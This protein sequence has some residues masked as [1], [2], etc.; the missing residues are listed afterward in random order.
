VNKWFKLEYYQLT[1]IKAEI[2]DL[3]VLDL[4]PGQESKC[5]EDEILGSQEYLQ[6]IKNHTRKT[7]H[8]GIIGMRF[9]I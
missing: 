6:D 8:I 7:R 2:A 9:P 4:L 5:C 1:I 3:L